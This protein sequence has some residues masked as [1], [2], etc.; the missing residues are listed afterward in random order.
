L[1]FGRWSNNGIN[2]GVWILGLY[3]LTK[4]EKPNDRWYEAKEGVWLHALLGF[5]AWFFC[6]NLDWNIQVI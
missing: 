3:K 2:F 4:L 6:K 1:D 5:I